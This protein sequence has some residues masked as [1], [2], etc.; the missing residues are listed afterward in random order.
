MKYKKLNQYLELTIEQKFEN[1]SIQQLFESYHLSKKNIHNLRMSKDVF[2][3]D[4]KIDQNFHTVLKKDDK[5]TFPFFIDEGI[6][7]IPQD[8]L[9]DIVYEDEFILVVNKQ[10]NMEVHPSLKDGTNALVNAVANYYQK[11][12]QKHRIRY[13]HRLDRDTTG[14]IVFVKN[15]FVHNLYDYLLSKKMIKRHYLA[16]SSNKPAQKKGI[17]DAPIA[18]DRHHNSKRIV[19]KTGSTA[20]TVYHIIQTQNNLNV[21]DIEL[22]TG[23]THQ[24]RVHLAYI[25][26]PILGDSLYGTITDKINR[27]ALHAYKITLIHPITF[28]PFTLEIKLPTDMLNLVEIL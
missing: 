20:K 19:S 1:N 6:D 9:L 8:I 17:I 3:N 22:F 10:A 25:D 15:Y 11:T 13:I 26:C 28:K 7:F 24:I 21:F 23:R 18:R 27:Q 2:L 5:L 14:I 16:I 12:D 4:E